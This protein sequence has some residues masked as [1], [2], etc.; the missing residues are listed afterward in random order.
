MASLIYRILSSTWRYRVQWL[1]GI[2]PVDFNTRD[3]KTSLFF[4]HW[5]GDELALLGLCRHGKFLTFSSK[6]KDGTIMAAALKMF[7]FKVIR[8]SSTRGGASALISLI[9]VLRQ[10]RFYVSR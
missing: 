7:G 1:E 9:K 5:H 4:A 6:S 10:E 2:S 8:G 3:P